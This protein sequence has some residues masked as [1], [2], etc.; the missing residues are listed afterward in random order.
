MYKSFLSLFFENYQEE[1][2]ET[3]YRFESKINS[4]AIKIPDKNE[5]LKAI[6]S[7][8]SND[9]LYID[10]FIEESDVLTID[11]NNLDEDLEEIHRKLKFEKDL[12]KVEMKMKIIKKGNKSEVSIYL[13]NTFIEGLYKSNLE[14]I[15]KDFND[16]LSR[17]D[18]I[19]FEVL[20]ETEVAFYSK[21]LIFNSKNEQHSNLDRKKLINKRNE[22][23]NL[24]NF[25]DM[26]LLPSDFFL[27]KES[28]DSNINYFFEKLT[29]VMSLIFISDISSIENSDE[30][31][32][33]INGYKLI[34][35]T[36]KFRDLCLGM[37]EIYE[38]YEWIF[39]EGTISD[40]VGLARNVISLN[41]K[42]EDQNFLLKSNTFNSIKSGYSIYLK[43]NVQQ[44]IEVTNKMSEY[45]IDLTMKANDVIKNFGSSFRNNNLIVASFFLSVIVFNSLSARQF[46][47]IFSGEILGIAVVIL[48]VS[49]FYLFASIYM[50]KEQIKKFESDY[51]HIKK[52]YKDLLN[53][54]DLKKIF[55]NEYLNTNI[56][57]VKKKII[58]FSIVWGTEILGFTIL[59]FIYNVSKDDVTN[60]MSKLVSQIIKFYFN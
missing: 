51:M 34:N 42:S 7:F 49:M 55:N 41:Y 43:E 3:I 53:P 20:D 21:S 46:T 19:Y 52:I 10:L 29:G 15:L 9:E 35:E 22:V 36:L 1:V 25:P 33:K 28:N 30:L 56:D 18:K 32:F 44:Y 4:A 12:S 11:K 31:H 23:S 48:F 60:V 50:I 24:L 39:H 59:L 54:G 37:D 5:L 57:Y 27:L 16:L 6:N 47:D 26:S 58:A 2:K 40:K 17:N 8:P 13:W 45:L 38:I 14:L